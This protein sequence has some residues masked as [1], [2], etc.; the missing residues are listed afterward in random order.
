MTSAE[1][2][3]LITFAVAVS[4]QDTNNPPPPPHVN[5]PIK[6]FRDYFIRDNQSGCIEAATGSGCTI[7]ECFVQLIKHF[8]SYAKPTEDDSV[9]LF[10]DNHSSHLSWQAL[11]LCKANGV[12]LLS[13]PPHWSHRPQPSDIS[14]TGP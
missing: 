4:A 2:G 12:I 9:L 13:F 8:I 6:Q 3:E 14:H 10:P 11:D 5:F 7:E 1:R